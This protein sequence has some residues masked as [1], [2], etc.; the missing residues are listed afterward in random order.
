MLANLR[1]LHLEFLKQRQEKN[2][3]KILPAETKMVHGCT[4]GVHL[5]CVCEIHQM[6]NFWLQPYHKSKIIKIFHPCWCV[7]YVTNN[8]DC[9]LHNCDE[10][11][12][13]D[14]LRDT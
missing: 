5:V 8:Q 3:F 6:Q 2:V 4:S 10:Y 12:H 1:E 7:I 9:M 11:P 13:K 14:N